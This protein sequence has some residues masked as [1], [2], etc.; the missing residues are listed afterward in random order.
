MVFLWSF[1]F[2]AQESL[3]DWTLLIWQ[4]YFDCLFITNLMLSYLPS[5][6]KQN[7]HCFFHYTF[8]DKGILTRIPYNICAKQ[9]FYCKKFLTCFSIILKRNFS[10]ILRCFVYMVCGITLLVYLF[11]AEFNVALDF[12][13]C[14][15]IKLF[16]S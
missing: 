1:N 8:E 10:V 13:S 12:K 11:L 6:W 5:P 9:S 14:D 3:L 16:K 4:Q 2:M 15:K 7:I